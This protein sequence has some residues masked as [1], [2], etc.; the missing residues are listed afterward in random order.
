[1]P[2]QN[3]QG[4]ARGHCEDPMEVWNVVETALNDLIDR[5]NYSDDTYPANVEVEIHVE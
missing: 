3:K 1:M 5:E 2:E 4:T